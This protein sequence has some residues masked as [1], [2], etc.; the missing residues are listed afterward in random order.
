[1]P[2]LQ[3]AI[4][5]LGSAVERVPTYPAYHNLGYALIHRGRVETLKGSD[6]SRTYERAVEAFE[7][8]VATNPRVAFPH[9]GL[10]TALLKLA[11]Y[12]IDQGSDPSALLNR[13]E[14]SLSAAEALLPGYW[15]TV[16]LRGVLAFTRARWLVSKNA[17]SVSEMQTAERA[18]MRAREL[19]PQESSTAR[20]LANVYLLRADVA[21]QP[22]AELARALRWTDQALAD[23]PR[24]A[25]NLRLSG[26][27][28]VRLGRHTSDASTIAEGVRLL[29]SALAMNRNL[30]PL[31]TPWLG[32]EKAALER[33]VARVEVAPR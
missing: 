19:N 23:D 10:A 26:I 13:A 1:M 29:E 17:D 21:T 11:D 15:E 4:N 7:S 25:E 12:S 22:D 14:S 8:G 24:H 20:E 9:D 27:V 3:K 30:E 28:R 32:T 5:H 18:L 6:P 31:I 16:F 2:P 33:Q